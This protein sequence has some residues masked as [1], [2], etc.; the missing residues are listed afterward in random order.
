ML[1]CATLISLQCFL[2]S[3]FANFPIGISLKTYLRMALYIDLQSGGS[4]YLLL[5]FVTVL[6][7][8]F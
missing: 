8:A 5:L 6:Q 3:G 1:Y 7:I 2:G 4:I